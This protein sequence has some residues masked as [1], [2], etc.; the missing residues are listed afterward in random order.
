MLGSMMAGCE[1]APGE[2]EIY[3]GGLQGLRGMGSLAS[4]AKG[5]SRTLFTGRQ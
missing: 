1:E 2:M 5:Y 4:M 3:Q